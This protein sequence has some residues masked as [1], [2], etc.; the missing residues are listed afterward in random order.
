MSKL[1][2]L[3]Q[4]SL[5]IYTYRFRAFL[6]PVLTIVVCMLLVLFFIIPQFQNWI[7]LQNQIAIKQQRVNILTNNLNLAGKINSSVVDKYLQLV[8]K[9][10]PEHK[11]YIGVLAAISTASIDS[12]VSLN[13][14]NFV[15]GDLSQTGTGIGTFPVTI[16]INGSLDDGRRFVASLKKIF[17]LS[18]VNGLTISDNNVITI[19]LLFYYKAFPSQISFQP[20]QP[21]KTLTTDEE[22]LLEALVQRDSQ[23]RTASLLIQ[24]RLFIK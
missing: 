6:S 1:S 2:F 16:T 13:D 8:S 21:L 14:Y 12:S 10:L 23:A 24:Q 22:S 11:D 19:E 17:P 3:N 20:E 5:R 9:A 7:D 18:T 4:T 15:V